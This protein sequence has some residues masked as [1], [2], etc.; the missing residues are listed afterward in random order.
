MKT[1]PFLAFGCGLLL[2]A[3]MFVGHSV[4]AISFTINPSTLPAATVG[5]AYNQALTAASP[6]VG[7]V[8]W[9]WSAVTFPPGLSLSADGH[10]TGIPTAA[11]TYSVTIQ[12]TDSSTPAIHGI[13]GYDITV[14]SQMYLSLEAPPLGEVGVDYHLPITVSVGTP[15]YNWTVLTPDVGFSTSGANSEHIDLLLAHRPLGDYPISFQVQDS[16]GR[17]LTRSWT[18]HIGPALS[19]ATSDVIPFATIGFPYSF[20]L[21]GAGG[22]VPYVWEGSLGGGLAC[23]SAGII[24]GTPTSESSV[25]T[26]FLLTDAAGGRVVKN[27]LVT[28]VQPLT[29]A[30]AGTLSAGTVGI[31]Y[32]QAFAGASGVAPYAYSLKSGTLPNGLTLSGD[33]LQGV[34]TLQGSFGFTIRV[35]DSRGVLGEQI[36][37]MTINPATTPTPATLSI[38]TITLSS[39]STIAAY[40]QTLYASGGTAPYSWFLVSGSLPPGLV[41]GSA[42]MLSGVPTTVG[43]FSFGLQ[44]RDASSRTAV[45]TF[46]VTIAGVVPSPSVP[47]EAWVGSADPTRLD[48]LRRIGVSVNDLVKLPNDHDSRTTVDTT[49]YYIGGDGFRHAFPTEDVYFSW[50]TNWS[51]IREVSVTDMGTLPLGANVTYKPGTR[52]VKFMTLNHVYA[53]DR[54]GV[55]RWVKSGDVAQVLYGSSWYRSVRDIS[56]AFYTNY[57]FGTD[58]NSVSDFNRTTITASVTTVTD[59]LRRR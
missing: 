6:A 37:T 49:V 2:A 52:L 55:L 20:S 53:V 7:P 42:G 3:S 59:S 39:G 31:A 50:Y 40:N 17:L 5:T 22:V 51:G 58:I 27:I 18:V 24:S 45:R 8:T 19:I 25:H 32:N 13:R 10:L 16:A 4:K 1:T 15:P 29:I 14:L 41:L 56:E 21:T 47:P 43:S 35:V 44:V 12:G 36:Y 30:P 54:W 46:T 33:R 48:N 9:V 11:G 26:D 38:D 28:A 34:P 23:S 57:G